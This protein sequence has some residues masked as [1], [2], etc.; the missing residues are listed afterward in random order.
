MIN[1]EEREDSI[2]LS[3]LFAVAKRHK[4][5]VAGIIVGCTVIAIII[6]LLLP[7][8][9]ESTTLV[10]TRNAGRNLGTMAAA[11]AAMGFNIGSMN[12]AP[13]T[14][15][16]IELMKSRTVLEPIIDSVEWEDEKKK[17]DAETFAKKY[18]EIENAKKTNLITVTAKGET[19]EEAQKISQAVV[20]N[21]LAM[22]TDMNKETQSMLIKFLDERLVTAKQE[23]DEAAQK[24]AD[25]SKDRK[26]YSPSD[27]AKL[28]LEQ[29][30]AYD[31]A[32]T[33]MEV[34]QKS[35]Q[36][37]YDAAT[38]KLGEQKAGAKA[39]NINDNSTV[40]SIRSQ[41]VT[42]EVELVG[43][44]Q[45]YTDNHP[46]VIT[47]REQL[48]ELQSALANEVNAAVDSNAASLNPAQ[49]EL[50]KTQALAQAEA[51]A[52][53]A[54]ESAL[55][56]KRDAKETAMGDFPDDVMTYMQLKRDSEI[57]DAV[58]QNLVKES[59]KDKIQEAMESMDVQ[60]IDPANLPRED[61]PSGPRKK[62]IAAVGFVIGCLGAFGYS[63]VKYK[64]EEA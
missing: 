14:E 18:L 7:K 10:Q 40:Q 46:S 45:R 23:S 21:F 22:E 44:E 38:S 62:L 49:A 5:P 53:S 24:L 13:S 27:Q 42:K 48:D 16:Y 20:D 52:A 59:E 37:Q 29:L 8:Q 34:R 64:K 9:W 11:A 50:L 56:E 63:L 57:K 2:D 33:D 36:A 61:R 43:L 4:K 54:S 25:F 28:A 39:Y 1:N 12:S 55:R 51:S 32:I 30:S 15:S 47:A 26:V 3:K 41:I 6:S 31:K 19:P 35:A 17:P 60:I 58:Y